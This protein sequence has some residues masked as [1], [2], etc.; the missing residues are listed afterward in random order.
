M[1]LKEGTLLQGGKYRIVRFIS[2]G[3]FGC[4]YEAVHVM[5]GERMAIKEFFPQQ[6]CNRDSMTSHISVSTDGNRK[7]VEKARRKFLEEARAL[8][9]MKNMDIVRVSDIF[10][11]NGTAYYAMEYIDGKSLGKMLKEQGPLPEQ[12]AL[13]YIRQA[14][15]ALEY[16]HS[17]NRLHLDIKPDNIM[18]DVHD[19]AIL[20]DF[21]ASKHYDDETGESPSTLVGK[22]PGYAPLEQMGNDVVKFL[23]ATD[24]YSLGATLYKLLTG[25]TPLS[26]NKIASGEKLDP[27]PA[28]VSKNTA[29]AISAAMRPIKTERPQSIAEFLAILDGKKTVSGD[30]TV[31]N[32]GKNENTVLNDTNDNGGEIE[33]LSVKPLNNVSGGNYGSDNY[34]GGNYGSGNYGGGNYGSDNGDDWQD[35]NEGQGS[36][37]KKVIIGIIVVAVIALIVFLALPRGPE[38]TP[39]L[40]YEEVDEIDTLP[41]EDYQ[42]D[43]ETAA[44]EIAENDDNEETKSGAIQQE[45]ES[46]PTTGYINGHEYVDLGLSVKWATCNVGASSPSD[47]GSYFAWGETSTKSSYDNSNCVTMQKSLGDI[48]GD[49]RYDAAR[50]NWGSSWRLPTYD[51]IS[52]LIKQC[53]WTWTTQ[54]NING[55]M[56]IG[57]NGNSLFLPAAG[58]CRGS[59]ISRGGGGN[60]WCSFP[61]VGST[62]SAHGLGFSKDGYYRMSYGRADG[63]SVRPVS[64]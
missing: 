20:I 35:D 22:T 47:Y 21:G 50:A 43:V 19:N 55:Y 34:S 38:A 16:V 17:Q 56:V 11:E 26:A 12:R 60:Y 33:V 63:Q 54:G 57:P 24:I 6:F 44:T 2:S 32:E 52:E 36:S 10:E 42:S 59:S 23:P 46:E 31:I 27:L 15:S 61:N 48:A 9:Q 7:I 4:T 5:L 51:E 40:V 13:R 1:H 29:N 58:L 49:E 8:Y 39:E 28:T 3:G 25:I 41:A 53:K 18:I 64:N 62:Q 30:A 14:A 45:Q 37:T